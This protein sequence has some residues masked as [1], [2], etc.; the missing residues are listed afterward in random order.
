MR[1]ISLVMPADMEVVSE[2]YGPEAVSLVRIDGES[3]Y[4]IYQSGDSPVLG[5]G[6]VLTIMAEKGNIGGNPR[7]RRASGR[8][9]EAMPSQFSDSLKVR[10]AV[11]DEESEPGPLD[12]LGQSYRGIKEY[13]SLKVLREDGLGYK[14]ISGSYMDRTLLSYNGSLFL[15]LEGDFDGA[16]HVTRLY[17]RNND[18]DFEFRHEF[19]S[20]NPIYDPAY[21][22]FWRHGAHWTIHNGSLYVVQR[23]SGFEGVSLKVW[24]CS[25][26]EGDGWALVSE[27]PVLGA[28]S[29]MADRF[30]VRIASG[31]GVLLI[32]IGISGLRFNGYDEDYHKDYRH[33]TSVD[34]GVTFTDQSRRVV[35]G[36]TV[37]SSTSMGSFSSFFRGVGSLSA[38]PILG[39]YANSEPNFALYYDKSMSSF[40]IMKNGDNRFRTDG[41]GISSDSRLVALKTTDGDIG[42][43]EKCL[44]MVVDWD[45]TGIRSPGYLGEHF[46]ALN[47]AASDP[48]SKPVMNEGGV[49]LGW[50]NAMG[51][52]I[53]DV[54]VVPGDTINCLSLSVEL[55]DRSGG[56]FEAG[57]A[58][59]DFR[60][61]EDSLFPVDVTEGDVAYG[62]KN[63]EMFTFCSTL[64]NHRINGIAHRGV[65]PS[66]N[67]DIYSQMPTVLSGVQHLGELLFLTSVRETGVAQRMLCCVLGPISN[68]GEKHGYEFSYPGLLGDVTSCGLELLPSADGVILQGSDRV[69]MDLYDDGAITLGPSVALI[70]GGALESETWGSTIIR[71]IA[72]SKHKYFKAKFKIKV[73]SNMSQGSL[74]VFNVSIGRTSP[75]ASLKRVSLSLFLTPS[76]VMFKHMLNLRHTETGGAVETPVSSSPVSTMDWVEVLISHCPNPGDEVGVSGDQIIVMYREAGTRFWEYGASVPVK[77]ANSTPY[78]QPNWLKIGAISSIDTYL[79]YHTVSVSDIQVSTL[80][81][82]FRNVY[83]ESKKGSSPY[84]IEKFAMAGAVIDRGIGSL[85]T[86]PIHISDRT[87]VLD[88][89]SEVVFEGGRIDHGSYVTDR[90]KQSSLSTMNKEKTVLNGLADSTYDFTDR[91][92]QDQDFEIVFKNKNKEPVDSVTLVNLSGVV[93]FTVSAGEYDEGNRTWTSKESVEYTVPMI[94][95]DVQLI[96]GRIVS[97]KDVKFEDSQIAGYTLLIQDR[98]SGIWV[99][100]R[101]IVN[102][103]DTFVKIDEPVSGWNSS[104]YRFFVVKDTASYDIS[105]LLDVDTFSSSYY[106][107]SFDSPDSATVRSVG[108]VSFGRWVDLSQHHIES[109]STT[110]DTYDLLKSEY[111]RIFPSAVNKGNTVNTIDLDFTYLQTS[112]GESDYVQDTIFSLRR[113][114]KSFPLIEM[115]TDGQKV[116]Y[117]AIG[118]DVSV[119]PESYGDSLQVKLIGQSWGPPEMSEDRKE[120]P[121]FDVRIPAGSVDLYIDNAYSVGDYNPSLM[122][123]G[124]SFQWE[125][126]DGTRIDGEVISHAYMTLGGKTITVRLLDSK[127]SAVAIKRVGLTVGPGGL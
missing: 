40:V 42:F 31:S 76:G 43:W 47:L 17:K 25:D 90:F 21:K 53:A 44:D 14:F 88:D 78:A 87:L 10:Y 113:S 108:E 121:T 22:E 30:R 98:A 58:F 61:I 114:G 50:G 23:Y 36:L 82:G 126:G 57:T 92:L 9:G 64:I 120:I 84:Y 115:H 117:V 116:N 73:D 60:F 38:D 83:G 59:A 63:H 118:G 54:H 15:I 89:G 110:F 124:Y 39:D 16:G 67:G 109:K 45:M 94:E 48:Y 6:E 123:V 46:V 81:E 97:T 41:F 79:S 111:G 28:E 68:I 70:E 56:R 93:K 125:M 65:S 33:F 100:S 19:D 71:K 112:T 91:Y 77:F 85:V 2:D 72:L 52:G 62:Q 86:Y 99:D 75:T 102:N 7:T 122:P 74:E 106:G 35:A 26:S 107:L 104:G 80:G 4:E 20:I 32:A 27:T 11:G 12:F 18:G 3:Q 8:S 37:N 103:F 1:Y 51:Y 66:E 95:L 49:P 13:R 105:E 55:I 5:D 119:G 69:E 101:I 96:D 127:G 34:D 24:K 29:G